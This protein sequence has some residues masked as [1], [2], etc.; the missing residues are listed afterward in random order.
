MTSTI[1]YKVGGGRPQPFEDSD[2][3]LTNGDY[4]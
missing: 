4:G 1:T 3:R 2:V